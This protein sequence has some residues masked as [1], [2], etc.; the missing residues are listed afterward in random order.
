MP[1]AKSAQNAGWARQA[2]ARG[3][4]EA[5]RQEGQGGDAACQRAGVAVKDEPPGYE[6]A[7][8]LSYQQALGASFPSPEVLPT[9]S[10][11]FHADKLLTGLANDH[12]SPPG[13]AC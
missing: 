7:V 12:W 13:G 4:Q 3:S 6:A 9:P 10:A 11:A 5:P 1:R 2:A 8:F